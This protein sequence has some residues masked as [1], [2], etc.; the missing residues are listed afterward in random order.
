MSTK[1]QNKRSEDLE[2][3]YTT[4]KGARIRFIGVNPTLIDKLNNAGT[5]PEVPYRETVIPDIGT[6]KDPLTAN[7]LQTVEEENQWAEYVEKRDAILS[8]RND[9][10]L[11]AI[12]FH[13]V[14]IDDSTIDEWKKEQE[15]VWGLEVPSNRVDL[16]VDYINSEIVGNAEDLG[17]IIAGVLGKA[18]VP[19]DK[20]DEM[21]ATF[22]G[23]LRGETDSESGEEPLEEQVA[24][25]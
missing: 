25:E 23:A 5:L 21:R 8:R 19:K 14:D 3:Y 2:D 16:K 1:Q 18:G 11:K 9:N 22:R 13:G 24:V 4:A 20:L 10:F 15:E 12:F 17:N 6:E 7:D